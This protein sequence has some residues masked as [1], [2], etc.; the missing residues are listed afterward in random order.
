MR[1]VFLVPDLDNGPIA[2]MRHKLMQSKARR[3]MPKPPMSVNA[4]FGGTLNIMRHAAVVRDLGKELGVEAVLATESGKDTYTDK[5]GIRG[6]KYIAWADLAKGDVALIP[7]LYVPIIDK[8]KN[9]AIAY[10]QAPTQLHRP[11]EYK[12]PNVHLWTDSPFMVEK[13]HKAY[14]GKEPVIIPNVV[15]SGMFPFIPQEKR[16]AGSLFVFPRKGP[17][18]IDATVKAYAAMGGTYW[19]PEWVDGVTIHELAMK[20]REPQAFLASADSE[21]CALPP[22]EC[23]AGGI[24]VVGKHAQGANFCM[25]HG[26]TSLIANT[27]EEAAKCLRDA[28]DAGLRTRLAENGYKAISR[29]FPQAEP[30]QVWRDFLA[31]HG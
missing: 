4:T 27:P 14:P 18:F 29:F 9:V 25:V 26:E 7:D 16:K 31:K 17:D 12:R 3:F 30:S 10:L 2:Q 23:M 5:W 8:L 21:G 20:M 15:D 11:F 6:L 13:V 28:E 22:Q 19:K 24:V 1:V